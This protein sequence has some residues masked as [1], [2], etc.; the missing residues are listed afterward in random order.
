MGTLTPASPLGAPG[1][2]NPLQVVQ[3]VCQ[4]P[5][6]PTPGIPLPCLSAFRRAVG[7]DHEKECTSGSTFALSMEANV[8]DCSFPPVLSE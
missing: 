8:E 3:H 7:G 2:V 6:P 5:V 1:E 4:V